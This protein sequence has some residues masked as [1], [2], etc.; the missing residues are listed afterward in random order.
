MKSR[1]ENGAV[2]AFLGLSILLL[3][4]A[5]IVV[6]GYFQLFASATLDISMIG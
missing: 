3:F 4:K 1:V 5:I 6:V 2:V